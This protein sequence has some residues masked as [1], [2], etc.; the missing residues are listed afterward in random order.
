MK[1]SLLAAALAVAAFSAGAQ[2]VADFPSKPVR[3]VIGY[4]PGGGTDVMGR[5]VATALGK[6]W[7]HNVIV[8]NKPGAGANIAAEFVAKSV[9]DGHTLLMWHDS[10][11]TNATLYSKLPYDP[12]KDLAPLSTVARVSLVMGVIPSLP[13]KSVKELIAMAKAQPGSLA[14]AS[15]G[16]GTPHHLAGEMF[17]SMA[18]VN[19]THVSY[20]GCAPALADILGGHIPVFFQTISTVTQQMKDGKVRVLAVADPQ[21]LKDY[22]D[23]PTMAEAGVPGYALTPWYGLFAPGPTP[24]PLVEKISADI[25]KVVEGAELNG[26]LRKLNFRPETATPDEMAK[27]VATDI[28]R[29]GKVVKAAG[30]KAE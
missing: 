5:H 21:R 13:A 18:E 4:P 8:E 26:I 16:P 14:Y 24:K 17:K 30:M 3:V 23:L 19:I 28:V 20:K 25:R 9:P 1:R 12:V 7:G 11:A 10:I 29:L 6:L 22:P 15:C 2:G 27:M